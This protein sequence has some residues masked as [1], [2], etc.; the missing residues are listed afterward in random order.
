[1]TFRTHYTGK[2]LQW[3]RWGDAPLCWK[4]PRSIHPS[5][6]DT[7]THKPHVDC[8]RCLAM[9]AA[10]EGRRDDISRSTDG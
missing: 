4:Y 1:M 9:L 5:K 6:G 3:G 7:T 8:P 10:I 2:A